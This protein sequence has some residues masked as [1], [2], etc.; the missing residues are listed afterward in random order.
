[1]KSIETKESIGIGI[2][3]FAIILQLFN[4]YQKG[5]GTQTDLV[6]ISSW[7]AMAGALLFMFWVSL[8]KK[9]VRDNTP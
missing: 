5:T 4:L 7:I 9:K 8:L 6:N 1:M 2:F 3:V